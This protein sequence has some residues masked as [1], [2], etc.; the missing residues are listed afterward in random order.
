[1][2]KNTAGL[3]ALVVLAVATLLMI[4]VV[5]PNVG[6]KAPS[7]DAKSAGAGSPAPADGAPG[8]PGALSGSGDTT[9]VEA[10]GN[11]PGAGNAANPAD[12]GVQSQPNAGAASADQI[13][14]GQT[15]TDQTPA[16]Q[17]PAGQPTSDQA[18]TGTADQATPGQAAANQAG[19]TQAGATQAGGQPNTSLTPAA[20]GGTAPSATTAPAAGSTVAAD[21]A[22]APSFDVLRVEPDGSTVIA[23]RAAPNSKLEIVN[24][25]VVVGTA[26]VGGSGDF[27]AVFDK[28]LAPGDYQLTLRSTTPAGTVTA[29][30]EVA[31]VS[32]PKVDNGQLL[33][34][35]TKP[36]EASRILTAPA[37]AGT[38]A[39]TSPS[40]A[41][42]SAS[43]Q[44]AV[45]APAASAPG[46]VPSAASGANGPQ[47]ATSE[48][49]PTSPVAVSAVEIE[50][51]K[52]FVAGTARPN[53]TVRIY[54]D[55]QLV[56]QGKAD[57]QGRFVIDGELALSVGQHVI[58]VDMIGADGKVQLRA[59]VPFERPEGDQIAAV[60]QTPA[61]GADP[62][63][64]GAIFDAS[65]MEAAKA[66]ALLKAL[67]A[68]GKLPGLD[69]LAA[70]RSATEIALTSLAGVKPVAG[71]QTSVAD[72]V[73]TTT[74]AA[75]EA[76]AILKPVPRDAAAVGAVLGRLDIAMAR[77]L[78]TAPALA[79]NGS[80][81]V[82]APA[83]VDQ[84]TNDRAANA[85]LDSAAAQKTQ[86]NETTGIA[87]V[88]PDQPV[89]G[90]AATQSS[91]TAGGEP[92]T[93]QQAP[94]QQSKSSVIIRRGD[95]LW[96]ISRRVYGAGVRYTTIYVANED[97]ILDPDRILPGQV[98]G[99]PDKALPDAESQEIHRRHMQHTP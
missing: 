69:Q 70:A 6:D 29:S 34:M 59:A 28:P 89:A 18:G 47:P 39:A 41:A 84:V 92:Q 33:A 60:A 37:A 1:M 25:N 73:T 64:D 43:D 23:G 97:Q 46:V 56:G 85:Q 72:R 14:A 81:R 44:A 42:P 93:V 3:V 91:Q 12:A 5:L 31:T 26:D 79:A 27:A 38:P 48:A 99:V 15:P 9:T 61:S 7:T 96:Q 78:E 51:R 55:D 58:R 13:P 66:F 86:A 77:V 63:F 80:A 68:D 83:P 19:A 76:L 36:G 94:L 22:P 62:A 53:A 95:T 57:A 30:E 65:R 20:P 90:S 32:I 24:G 2:R 35:V 49:A 88:A 10:K 21:G 67:F 50:G 17:T 74:K 45:Q 98:F 11:R 54:A 52:L 75:A 40:S 87:P 82:T 71:M 16:N 8:T 4:F